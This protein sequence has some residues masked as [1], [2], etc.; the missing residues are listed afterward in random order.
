MAKRKAVRGSKRR[1]AKGRSSSRARATAKKTAASRKIA[2]KAARKGARKAK[3]TVKATLSGIPAP[4]VDVPVSLDE[5]IGEERIG[6]L[7]T[8]VPNTPGKLWRVRA[9]INQSTSDESQ[10]VEILP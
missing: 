1:A 8:T 5:V 3:A 10:Y 4:S 2:R 7:T 9:A 6:Y